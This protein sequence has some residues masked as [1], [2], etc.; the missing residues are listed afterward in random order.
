MS[1]SSSPRC[2]FF[3][4]PRE[5]RDIIYQ[6]ALSL[7]HGLTNAADGSSETVQLIAYAPPE[8]IFANPL[9]YVCRQLH[10]E[11]RGVAL[12]WNDLVIRF[13]NSMSACDVFGTFLNTCSP[14]RRKCLKKVVIVEKTTFDN[15]S[16]KY[17]KW[18]CLMCGAE[19]PF[20]YDYCLQHPDARVIVRHDASLRLVHS[21]DNEFDY[22]R[23][24]TFQHAG[25]RMA[26]RQ[27][28]GVSFS[29]IEVASTDLLDFPSNERRTL[30]TEGQLR[31][32]LPNLRCT[33]APALNMDLCRQLS[34]DYFDERNIDFEQRLAE[35]HN[36]Y[37]EGC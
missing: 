9:K 25:L 23:L 6:Y 7:E 28:Y 18:I 36:L 20:L 31:E 24:W 15:F 4:L 1:I 16:D 27:D 30:Q 37:E 14:T 10:K 33:V 35:L 19:K 8:Y 3:T 2:G 29:S 17:R 11:T 13:T 12:A 21:D 22:M 5:L 34:R 32:V 26:F